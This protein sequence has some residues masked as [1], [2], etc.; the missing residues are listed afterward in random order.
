MATYK[1]IYF[2][3]RGRAEISRLLFSLA[4]Q[5]YEDKRIELEEW[6]EFKKHTPFE[7]LPILEVHEEGTTYT[8]AQS[9][10]IARFLANRFN[11]AGRDE[12][13]KAQA[14]MIIDQLTDILNVLVKVYNENKDDKL[15]LALKEAVN[16]IVPNMLLPIES[17]LLAN[18]NGNGFLVGN[19]L[20]YADL[21][22]MYFYDS[23]RDDQSIVFKKLPHLKEHND[24]IRSL[25]SVADH[26]QRNAH[27]KFS[28]RW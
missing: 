12:L 2:N 23:L 7:K 19:S 6:P 20:T 4:N 21:R 17:I 8:I 1:L 9:I 18:K 5:N 3:F 24:R 16:E 13:E 27:I 14:D 28:S 10:A 15:I 22:L 26:L 11:L 25:P